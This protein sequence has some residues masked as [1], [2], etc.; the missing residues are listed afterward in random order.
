M[1]R[2][3]RE[4]LHSLFDL[5]P[6]PSNQSASGQGVLGYLNSRSRK[7][8]N[9]LFWKK[10]KSKAFRQHPHRKLILVEG[11]SWFEYPL[12]L[13]EIIDHLNKIP[14]YALYSLA[15]GGDWLSN[16][17]RE[18]EYIEELSL[19]QP[20]I[21][22]IGGG[23]N[24]LLGNH[25]L[26]QLLHKKQAEGRTSA[27][28]FTPEFSRLMNL[29]KQQYT[30]LLD[31]IAS[32]PRFQNMK[33]ITHG[34]DYPIPSRKRGLHPIKRFMGNGKWLKE[35]LELR[36]YYQ[37]EEQNEVMKQVINSFNEMLMEL[38][39]ERKN[40]AHIDLRG[41]LRKPGDWFDELHPRSK[42]FKEIANIFQLTMDS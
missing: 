6:T 7:R 19:L 1:N 28:F 30:T 10:L 16:I 2:E 24:D 36:G 33:I 31:Q 21:F 26:A 37:Q 11:D 20:D 4:E 27:S 9:R 12:F 25:R 38:T 14:H 15:A 23:G 3:G 35:P 17:L 29:L 13:K 32:S 34:Y 42:K 22:L 8:R 40:V 18:Q 5:N 41:T 39:R